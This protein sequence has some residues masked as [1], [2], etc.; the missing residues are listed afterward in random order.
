DRQQGKNSFH[1]FATSTC[2]GCDCAFGTRAWKRRT[3][4]CCQSVPALVFK[5]SRIVGSLVPGSG[6]S[7][8]FC[9]DS[10]ASSV[11]LDQVL[12]GTGGFIAAIAA[13]IC[14][15][16]C[17]MFVQLIAPGAV[18]NPASSASVRP[19]A[20]QASITGCVP[21]ASATRR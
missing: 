12:A 16:I 5:I 14:I 4:A 9:N 10:S 6:L 15:T 7:S 11:I 20:V 19:A 2:F 21:P 13:I 3:I 8:H 17:K 18:G 1:T